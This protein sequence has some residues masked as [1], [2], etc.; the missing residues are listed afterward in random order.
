MHMGELY[1]LKSISHILYCTNNCSVYVFAETAELMASAGDLE[2]DVK[3]ICNV[4]YTVLDQ[5][6]CSFIRLIA[7]HIMCNKSMTI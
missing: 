1:L 4:I 3:V 5:F 6:I 7:A 2:R